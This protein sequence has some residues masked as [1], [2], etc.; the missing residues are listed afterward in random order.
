M[1]Q[2]DRVLALICHQPFATL[3]K[4]LLNLSNGKIPAWEGPWVFQALIE[5]C[6]LPQKNA[7][8]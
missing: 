7:T 4:L 3:E 1:K 6:P 2:Q 5:A 8:L